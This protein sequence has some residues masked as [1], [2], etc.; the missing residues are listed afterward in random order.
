MDTQ[1]QNTDKDLLP[2]EASMLDEIVET[3]IEDTETE[4]LTDDTQSTF[5]T[6]ILSTEQNYSF[7]TDSGVPVVVWPISHATMVIEWGEDILYIDPAEELSAYEGYPVPNYVFVTHEHGDHYN[8]QVLTNLVTQEVTLVVNPAV[9][10]ML[11]E[12]LSGKAIVMANGDSQTVGPMSVDAIP[13]Y[14]IREEALNY[15]PEGRD[16][17]YILETDG[18]RMYISG[19]TEDTPELRALTDIDVAFVSMNLPYTM[20]VENAADGVLAF[21]PETIIPYHFRGM[22]GM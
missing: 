17:G 14:N 1:K 18:F 6:S 7:S 16:N 15:H 20:P 9:S 11:P 5:D 22:D 21:A 10:D 19:D 13:A 3:M 12:A 2:E 8:E 4:T